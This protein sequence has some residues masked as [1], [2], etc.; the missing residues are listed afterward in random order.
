[1]AFYWLR[2]LAGSLLAFH[3]VNAAAELPVAIDWKKPGD[4]LLT[5]DS[6]SGL[7]WLDLSYT[8]DRSYNDIVRQLG[9]GGEFE[10][11]R[12]ASIAEITGLW[13]NLGGVRPYSGASIENR[14]LFDIV[15]ALLG[16]AVDCGMLRCIRWVSADTYPSNLFNARWVARSNSGANIFDSFWAFPDG[17][18][19]D[20]SSPLY[21]HALVRQISADSA[22]D[23]VIGKLDNCP[24][25]SRTRQSSTGGCE[26][27]VWPAVEPGGAGADGPA[28]ADRYLQKVAAPA[29]GDSAPSSSPARRPASNQSVD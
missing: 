23:S 1:M 7:E 26:T 20:L 29:A 14:D 11:F 15:A 19:V 27:Q 17:L 5:Y 18:R 16:E 25:I 24:A 2:I 10:G 28:T 21:G 9:P 3:L 4:G 6:A 22:A 13:D 12:Y 8:T